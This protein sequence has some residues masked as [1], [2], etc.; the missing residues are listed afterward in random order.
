[1]SAVTAV[2]WRTVAVAHTLDRA[3]MGHC[4]SYANYEP[5]TAQFRVRVLDGSPLAM[6]RFRDSLSMQRG[7]YRVRAEDLPL[8]LIRY[9]GPGP[10]ACAQPLRVGD[11]FELSA[12]RWN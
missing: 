6:A 3:C 2:G 7:E 5:S 4:F 1:V 11:R 8:W 10:Q 9:C 12:P